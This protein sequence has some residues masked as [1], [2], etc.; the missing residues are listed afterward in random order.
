[1]CIQRSGGETE[2][3]R[4]FGRTEYRWDDSIGIDFQEMGWSRYIDWIDL[5]EDREEW[6]EVV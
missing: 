3:S 6:W 1:M 2:G 5:A 4:A